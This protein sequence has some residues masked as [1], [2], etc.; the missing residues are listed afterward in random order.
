MGLR[1]TGCE[2]A[3]LPEYRNRWQALLNM[4]MN[5]RFP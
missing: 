2:G 5:I 1:E 3:H 4:I